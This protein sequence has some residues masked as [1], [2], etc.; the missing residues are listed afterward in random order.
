MM[1]PCAKVNNQGTHTFCSGF[2]RGGNWNNGANAGAFTLNLNNTPGNTNNNIGF[3]CASDQ[4]SDIHP[5]QK[6]ART[7]GSSLRIVVQGLPD[8]SVRS[9]S[10]RAWENRKPV[11]IPQNIL[12][13]GILNGYIMHLG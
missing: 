4:T 13:S 11:F 8:H 3:R 12:G 2:I 1:T 6:A 5:K 9:L 10:G 7:S